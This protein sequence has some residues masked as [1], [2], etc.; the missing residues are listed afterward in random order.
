[1]KERGLLSHAI[2]SE[3]P[4]AK[5]T[6]TTNSQHLPEPFGLEN[7]ISAFAL[8]GG[9]VVVAGL[10]LLVEL[11]VKRQSK[12]TGIQEGANY[13]VYGDRPLPELCEHSWKKVIYDMNVDLKVDI[14]EHCNEVRQRVIQTKKKGEK[15]RNREK[16]RNKTKL[17]RRRSV[18]W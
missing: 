2:R 18:T 1:M 5:P 7:T 15:Q 14:C 9:A 12:Q 6:C 16:K 13:L 17:K 11:V 8:V 4:L 3:L 10:I